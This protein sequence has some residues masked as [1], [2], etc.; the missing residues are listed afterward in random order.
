MRGLGIC[1]L[2]VGLF[3]V[4]GAMSMDVS[5]SSGMGRVNNL[6]LMSERQNF[7][8]IGGI[9]ALGGLLML[10]LGGK[11]S[12]AEAAPASYDERPCPFC[13]EPIKAAAIKCRHC[14]SEV[15]KGEAVQMRSEGYGW[16]V[17]KDCDSPESV[18]QANLAFKELGFT[19]TAPDGLVAICGFFQDKEHAK[20]AKR[21]LASQHRLETY[22]YFQPKR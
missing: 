21:D 20:V 14:G 7:T 15:P 5:V 12:V 1:V 16:T 9:I 18:E 2:I 22:L 8:I 4:I 10:L 19:P 6:G 13:A 3:V 17:R 11:K